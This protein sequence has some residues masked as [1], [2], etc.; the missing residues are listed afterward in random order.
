MKFPFSIAGTIVLNR[1]D[2]GISSESYLL[3][4]MEECLEQLN[5][6][7]DRLNDHELFLQKT[8]FIKGLNRKTY[9]KNLLV[10]VQID[11]TRITIRLQTETILVFFFGAVLSFVLTTEKFPRA[12]GL[13]A[14]FG[15]ILGYLIKWL[16]LSSVKHDLE[17]Y[18]IQLRHS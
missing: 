3:N 2:Y 17:Q 10:S 14:L 16:V 6:S 13:F 11:Q 5:M 15:W 12:L 4:H 9:L 8:D 1:A 7:M 18:L